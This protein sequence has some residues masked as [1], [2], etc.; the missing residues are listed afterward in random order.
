MVAVPGAWEAPVTLGAGIG[1][2]MQ[3][4]CKISLRGGNQD[5]W[6]P[7]LVNRNDAITAHGLDALMDNQKMPTL[8]FIF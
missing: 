3:M 5:A 2:T 4:E 8:E 1:M 6:R 7:W